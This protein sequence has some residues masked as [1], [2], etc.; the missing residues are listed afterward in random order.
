[1]YT[2]FLLGVRRNFTEIKLLSVYFIPSLIPYFQASLDFA[3]LFPSDK[4]DEKGQKRGIRTK[5]RKKDFASWI[6]S[7]FLSPCPRDNKKD[8]KGQ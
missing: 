5:K 4:K 7:V 2:I 3:F 1:M 6:T 8:E